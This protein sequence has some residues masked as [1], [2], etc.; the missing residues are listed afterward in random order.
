MSYPHG[1]SPNQIRKLQKAL[2]PEHIQNRQVEGKTLSYIEGWYAISQANEIFGFGGWDRKMVH[3]E[4]VFEQTRS[5]PKQCGYLARVQ[6]RVRLENGCIVREGTGWGFAA[7]STLAAAH[8][9]AIKS[10]ETDGTK[11]ALS[12]FGVRFGL[13]LY[14]KDSNGVSPA[15]RMVLFT[16][17]GEL[18]AQDLSAEAFCAGLRQM[19]S[20]CKTLEDL[21]GLERYHRGLLVLLE[22]RFPALRNNKGVHFARL[23]QRLLDGAKSRLQ[24]TENAQINSQASTVMPRKDDLPVADNDDGRGFTGTRAEGAAEGHCKIDKSVLTIGVARRI[25]DKEHL[26]NVAELPCTICNR[27]PSQAH[28]LRFAQSRGLGQKASDE[29]VVPL[30]GLHHG[31]LHHSQSEVEWWEKQNVTPLPLAQEL[32]HRHLRAKNGEL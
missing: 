25:R 5:E 9:K 20:A 14:D 18:F 26:R 6:I 24:A 23:L 4:K 11:R 31:D 1:F 19:A 7:G 17:I 10:A 16:P 3:F 28:H 29:F 15:Q 27:Q 8:E 22:E 13:N 21:E 32:W 2:D 30:C 12:T